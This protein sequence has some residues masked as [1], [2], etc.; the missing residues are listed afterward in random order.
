MAHWNRSRR[1]FS[2]GWVL[3]PAA[4]L[5][6]GGLLASPVWAA[7]P[8]SEPVQV[9]RASGAVRVGHRQP[10][11]LAAGDPLGQHVFPEEFPDFEDAVPAAPVPSPGPQLS[12]EEFQQQVIR[13][14]GRWGMVQTSPGR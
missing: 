8:G 2:L 4:A 11:E 10:V 6:L 12:P 9:A 1:T 14:I 5:V 7:G 13:W 3:L